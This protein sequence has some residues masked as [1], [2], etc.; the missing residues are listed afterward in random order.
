MRQRRRVCTAWPFRPLLQALD[1]ALPPAA[2][3]TAAL[4]MASYIARAP[5]A[6][7]AVT[8][9]ACRALVGVCVCAVYS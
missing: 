9:K 3:V 1:E 2:R 4:Y 8:A 6:L 7:G 5:F